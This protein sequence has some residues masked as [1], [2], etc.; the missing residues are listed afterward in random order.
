MTEN[1]VPLAP[2]ENGT[3]RFRLRDCLSSPKPA[4]NSERAAESITFT[5][6]P[7]NS[8]S[9]KAADKE[10]KDFSAALT[11]FVSVEMTAGRRG[12]LNKK[13][14]AF[15]PLFFVLFKAYYAAFCKKQHLYVL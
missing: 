6:P 15:M 4:Y 13:T 8:R 10:R 1:G 12:L 5:I 7:F 14:A 2:F 3:A 11:S 9:Q